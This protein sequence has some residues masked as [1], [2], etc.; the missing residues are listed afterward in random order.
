MKITVLGLGPGGIDL[1]PVKNLKILKADLPIFLRTEQHPVVEE[2]R[3][4]G[5]KF[6]SFDTIYEKHNAFE[7]VYNEIV[8]VLIS[9]VKE[10]QN[11]IIYGVPGNPMVAEK[12][13][14][15]LIKKVSDIEIDLITAPSGLEAV[16][17][18]LRIDP[19]DGLVILDALNFNEKSLNGKLPLLFTQVYNKMVASELKLTLMDYYPEEHAIRVVKGAGISDQEIIVEVP[20]YQLDRLDWIDHLTSLYI[21]AF[22]EQDAGNKIQDYNSTVYPAY[23]LDPLVEVMDKL[24]GPNGCPWDQE[25]NHNSLKKY[26]IEEAYEVLDAIDEKN[27]NKLCEELGD[28]LLQVVF[29]TQIAVEKNQFDINDVISGITEK[30]IRR[31]PHVFAG[32]QVESAGEVEVN[33]EDIKEQEKANAEAK[34]TLLG[35]IPKNL[36]A[37]PRAE[38]IQKKA[39]RVGFDWPDIDGPW[40]KVKE[41]LH[42]FEEAVELNNHTRRQEEMG[43][44]LFALVNIC[45]FY[46]IDPEKALQYTNDKFIKRFAYIE[47]HIAQKKLDW[48]EL[49]LQYLDKLWEEAKKN[50]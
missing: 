46:R 25:Q 2:L 20:L 37:L 13:V 22:K 7:D 48:D 9:K 21:P 41:E 23:C 27:M 38:K 10:S 43:D 45:R 31:H 26:L 16:Y 12:T 8:E 39:T 33:W 35:D 44:I 1:L 15:L 49:N 17:T 36:P 11:E 24:R 5:I 30:L 18:A 28:L 29:H 50:E 47:K 19:C 14:K 40:L 32:V 42:E 34:V 4:L 3:M 6:K